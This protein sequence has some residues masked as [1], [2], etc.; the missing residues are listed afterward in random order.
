MRVKWTLRDG[1]NMAIDYTPKKEKELQQLRKELATLKS[2]RK[3]FSSA[4]SLGP[5]PK[6]AEEMDNTKHI[7]S[8]NTGAHDTSKNTIMSKRFLETPEVRA[9]IEHKAT[10]LAPVCN[11]GAYT[12][13]TSE[14]MAK[15]AGRKV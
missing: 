2:K 3:R 9:E 14:E 12:V 5:K 7:P 4:T 13:I 10:L 6:V 8:R 15:T 1:G 11:K